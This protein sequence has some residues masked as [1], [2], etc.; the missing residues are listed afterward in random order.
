MFLPTPYFNPALL[1]CSHFNGYLSSLKP[2]TVRTVHEYELEYFLRS[3]GGIIVDGEYLPF[4]AGEIN[5]RKPGQVVQGIPP[6]ES[7]ILL[8]DV[9]GNTSRTGGLA[10]G[11]PEEAQECYENPLL[12]SLPKKLAPAKK[13][14]IAGLFETILQNQ[15][16]SNDLSFFQVRSSLYFL[17]SELFRESADQRV[18]GNTSAIRRAV[19]Y[20][21]QHFLESISIDQL[22]TDSGLSRSCFHR[23]FLEETGV[24][25]GR[26]IA[27]LRIEQAKNLLSVTS[28]PVGEIGA[29]CGYPDHV[30]FSRVFHQLTGMSPSSYR[31]LT[32]K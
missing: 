11:S 21:Q 8:A 13:D 7:Y 15:G 17:F 20:I 26:L 12:D 31:K 23:R 28:M 14:L 10:F 32:E 6:Y 18:T 27:S 9:V 19:C 1:R 3:D 5:I 4:T 30:Y 16:S 29:M 22:I 2:Y 25:P 24:T